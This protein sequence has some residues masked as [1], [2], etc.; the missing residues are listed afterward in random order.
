MNNFVNLINKYIDSSHIR[1]IVDAG[2]MDGMDAF[3]F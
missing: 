1:T 2:S 3:F